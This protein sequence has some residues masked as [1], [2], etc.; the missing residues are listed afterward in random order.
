MG[1]GGHRI[2]FVL[3]KRHREAPAII[4]FR[5]AFVGAGRGVR[6]AEQHTDDT[7]GTRQVVQYAITTVD[8]HVILV[9]LCEPL[10]LTGWTRP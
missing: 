1:E 10:A 5:D 7:V 9:S 2:P 8:L 4:G 3:L 6:N